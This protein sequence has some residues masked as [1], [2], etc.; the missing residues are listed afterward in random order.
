MF[1]FLYHERYFTK[2]FVKN[3]QRKKI[4]ITDLALCLVKDLEKQEESLVS[5]V[6]QPADGGIDSAQK[7]VGIDG[8][9]GAEALPKAVYRRN[10]AAP[11]EG[12]GPAARAFQKFRHGHDF[13]RYAPHAAAESAVAR[14]IQG[15]ENRGMRGFRGWGVG[16]GSLEENR[17]FPEPV[18]M[19]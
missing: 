17:V 10:I 12:S 16:N 4:G 13:C 15:R 11:C 1:L 14:D 3:R 5:V 6:L 8:L 9:V 18:D 19:G 7:S 2:R